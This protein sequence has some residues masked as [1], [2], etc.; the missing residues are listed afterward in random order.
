MT[1]GDVGAAAVLLAANYLMIGIFLAV[2]SEPDSSNKGLFLA[3][4][5]PVILAVKV[6]RGGKEYFNERP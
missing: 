2:A 4:A 1:F 6:Y 5:W 3:L